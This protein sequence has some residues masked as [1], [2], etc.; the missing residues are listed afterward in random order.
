[1][2]LPC[3][4]GVSALEAAKKTNGSKKLRVEEE[5]MISVRDDSTLD[6]SRGGTGGGTLCVPIVNF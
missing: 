5:E 2:M 4:S 1:M 3:R 6:R